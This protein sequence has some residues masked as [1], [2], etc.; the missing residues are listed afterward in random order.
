MRF[1]VRKIQWI[2]MESSVDMAENAPCR[3]VAR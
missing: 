1:D 2:F 3:K